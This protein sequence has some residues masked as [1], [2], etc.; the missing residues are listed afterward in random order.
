MIDCRV[1]PK[2]RFFETAR[3]V[4][5]HSDCK[6]KVGCIITKGNHPISVGFN[7]LKFN[8]IWSNPWRKT[9]HAEAQAL[10]T[11]G[12]DYIKNGTAYVYR[13]RHDGSIGLAKPCP[14]CMTK[15]I[16]KGIRTIY[17]STTLYPY[18]EKIEI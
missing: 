9:L 2:L 14:D 11:S 10:R 7:R 1:D 13:E 3:N 8:K 12:R 17:F 18:W 16:R 5:R 4:S 6:I 15:L